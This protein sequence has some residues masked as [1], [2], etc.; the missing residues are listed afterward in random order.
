MCV[1]QNLRTKFVFTKQNFRTFCAGYD[2]ILRQLRS[3]LT[4]FLR[5]NQHGRQRRC[6]DDQRTFIFLR[7]LLTRPYFKQQEKSKKYLKQTTTNKNAGS[8]NTREELQRPRFHRHR[9]R[10]F[11]I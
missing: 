9:A 6:R 7:A 5:S 8:T 3:C 10:E 11:G 2:E 1:R 4:H